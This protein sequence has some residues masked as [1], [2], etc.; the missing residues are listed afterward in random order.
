MSTMDGIL[1]SAST[2]AGN[3]LLL[4]AVGDRIAGKKTAEERQ[5]LA[6]RASRWILVAMGLVSF[7]IALDPPALVGL[8]AQAGIY[9]LV[10]ASLA[11][12]ALG[13]FVRDLDARAAFA[14]AVVGPLVHF[15]H[16]G[17]VTFVEG[18]T[19][20]PSVS[21]TEGVL[22]S[23]AVLAGATALAR[24]RRARAVPARA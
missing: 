10:A 12:V 4:G 16:Y 8:F 22:A 19:M 7:V 13:I 15:A 23:F 11:P 1:V 20:N 14:A 9:G 3:D 2:I 21:G 18:A 5:S 6:L 17:Y 24:L